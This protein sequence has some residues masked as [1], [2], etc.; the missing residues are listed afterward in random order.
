MKCYL[1]GEKDIIR[2]PGCARDKKQLKAL[3]CKN[4]DLVFLNSTKHINKDYYKENYTKEQFDDSNWQDLLKECYVDDKR[5]SAQVLRLA[6]NRSY[7]DVGCGTGGVL[8]LT[9]EFCSEVSGVELQTKW[10]KELIKRGFTIFDDL[11]KVNNAS[12]ELAS[13]FHVLGHLSDPMTF[14]R[15]LKSKI[16]PG[17]KLLIEVP[18][19]DDALLSLYH[20]T[21]FSFFTYLS[22]HLFIFNSKSLGLLFQKAGLK[23][24]NIKQIQR[25]PLSNHLKW[26]AKGKSG[27]H[28]TWG[29]INSKQLNLAYEKS[30]ASIGCC[31][32]LFATVFL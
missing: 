5:R 15:E 10:R 28:K 14:L 24:W 4:C 7:L 32:T 9:K 19:S 20:C 27:G 26:L 25:Y 11:R 6:S 29:F 23:K 22:P 21:A 12:V 16:K 17:G 2:L 3:Q 31:D 18:N 13:A 1:C 30:L 8:L